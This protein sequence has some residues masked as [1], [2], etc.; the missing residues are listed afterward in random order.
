MPITLNGS[1]IISGVSDIT[2]SNNITSNIVTSDIVKS[3]TSTITISGTTSNV[4]PLVSRTAVAAS[5]GS[6]TSIDFTDIPTWIRRATVLMANVSTS[7]SSQLQVQIGSG[8]ISNTGYYTAGSG[9]SGS[10][11]TTTNLT[12]GFPISNATA[13]ADNAT[14][15]G[16]LMLISD[17]TWVWAS[18]GI[19][20][21]GQQA[22]GAGTKTLSGTLDRIRITTVNGTDTFDGGTINI[23]YE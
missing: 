5:F 22:I 14:I 9:T 18:T 10:A 4:Y 6:P 13:A 16:T 12:T 7:S 21:L 2:V 1:G 15:I 11:I 20:L 19:R 3:N 8:S 23:T 17:T